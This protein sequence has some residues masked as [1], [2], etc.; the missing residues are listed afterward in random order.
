MDITARDNLTA[1]GRTTI[2]QWA[3][4]IYNVASNQTGPA[5]STSYPL[6]VTWR[7]TII[8]ATDQRNTGTNYQQ[9]VDFDLDE[10]NGRWCVTPEFPNGTYA[11]FV[12][13]DSNGAPVFPYNIGRAFYGSPAGGSV[14]GNHRNGCDEFPWQA[15]I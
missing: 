14:V 9:G 4:R 12:A 1:N 5:V 11:Y 8:S 2:P 13:I 3:V 15:P 6:G 10:Y 7:T